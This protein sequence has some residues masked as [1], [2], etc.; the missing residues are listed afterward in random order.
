MWTKIKFYIVISVFLQRWYLLRVWSSKLLVT[1]VPFIIFSIGCIILW[2]LILIKIN[3]INTVFVK[4]DF[5][6]V[7]IILSIIIIFMFYM[8]LSNYIWKWFILIHV[9]RVLININKHNSN[10]KN[11]SHTFQMFEYILKRWNKRE[12]EGTQNLSELKAGQC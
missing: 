2:S 7:C 11:I 9:H 4:L 1:W 5:N 12:G 8:I 10:K 3:V 6:L